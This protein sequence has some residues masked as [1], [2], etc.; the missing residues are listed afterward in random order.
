MGSFDRGVDFLHVAQQY[1]RDRTHQY[2]LDQPARKLMRVAHSQ[3]SFRRISGT[4]ETGEY[5]YRADLYNVA[6][7]AVSYQRNTE[8]AEML[9]FYFL[10]YIP[11]QQDEAVLMLFRRAQRGIRTI[12]LQ[13]FQTYF[14][15][16]Y[17]NTALEINP[18][19][20]QSIIDELSRGR[21]TKIRL[22]KYVIPTDIADA[23]NSGGHLETPG[24]LEMSVRAGRNGSWPVL[25]NVRDVLEGRRGASRFLEL[26]GFEYDNAKVEFD[27]GGKTRTV[28]LSDIMKL[29]SLVDISNDVTVGQDGH[30]VFN[31]VDV[32]ANNLLRDVLQ[33]MG[34][35]GRNVL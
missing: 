3:N 19:V 17:P 32:I 25:G 27:I 34:T 24:T 9:P 5:G 22:I 4:I 20:P 18:L 14:N 35:G 15:P 10:V 1:I 8:E 12:L 16:L 23:L 2:S 6:T 30:P 31:S 13:D 21:I 33:D 28:D 29:R 7:S 11:Q 26:D